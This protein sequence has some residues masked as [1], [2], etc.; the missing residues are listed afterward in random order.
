MLLLR[1]VADG[2]ATTVRHLPQSVYS[3]MGWTDEEGLCGTIPVNYQ[4]DKAGTRDAFGF[5]EAAMSEPV[6][7]LL[8]QTLMIRSGHRGAV[9]RRD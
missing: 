1:T 3:Y 2:R 4:V 7:T 9:Q 6:A 5:G 8:G